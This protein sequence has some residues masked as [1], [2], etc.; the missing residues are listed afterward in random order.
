MEWSRTLWLAARR[1]GREPSFA[2]GT[3]LLLA[4]G[5]G[6]TTAAFGVLDHLLWRPLPGVP[7]SDRLVSLYTSEGRERQG[8]SSY[9]D[10]RDLA[11]RTRAF[12]AVAAFK[13]LQLELN[14]D[15]D[16]GEPIR[17]LMVTGGYFRALGLKPAHGRFFLGEETEPPGAPAVVLGHDLWQ[18][19]FAGR[20]DALGEP[21]SIDGLRCTIVG[22]APPGFA[23]TSEDL[24]AG[25]FV[26]MSLQPHLMGED[27]LG[28]R[29][30]GGVLGIGRLAPRASL[31]EGAADL[32]RVAAELAREF[33]RTNRDRTMSLEPLLD[34]RIS[35]FARSLWHGAG[36]LLAV[37]V[38]LVLMV[39]C[40]NVATLLSTR[41][42]SRLEELGIRR[43]LGA[44]PGRLA[45]ELA[46]ETLLIA[47]SGGACG[48]LA[49]TGVLALAR[50]APL[51]ALHDVV[52]DGRALGVALAATL[53][54]ALLA[55][56][57]PLVAARRQLAAPL[58]A[59]ATSLSRA[60]TVGV[61]LQ[62]MV[63]LVLLVGASLFARTL[64]NLRSVPLGFD[65]RGL[66]VGVLG[67]QPGLPAGE[68]AARW[69]A[70]GDA[71][72]AV[73]GVRAASLT[74]RLPGGSDH[75]SMGV[76][77]IN[78]EGEI[79]Q[80]VSVQAV[81]GDYFRALG[82]RPVAGRGLEAADERAAAAVTVVN[83]RMARRFWPGESVLGRT[84]ELLDV[85]MLTIVG[86]VPDSKDG[87]LRQEV[88]PLFY[89]PWSLNPNPPRELYL[90]ARAP[91]DPRSLREAV[92]RAT[93]AAG[94]GRVR[95]IGSF[96]ELLAVVTAPERTAVTLLAGLS[97]LALLLTAVG[98]YS[99]LAWSV[100]QRTRELGVRAALG[101]D[102]RRL[103]RLVL[104]QALRIAA[105]GIVLGTAGG[106]AAARASRAVL[107]GVAPYDP[108]S[109]LA[110]GALL[111]L[112]AAVAAWW[113]ARRATR[114]DPMTALRG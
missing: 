21:V 28:E 45:G 100:A 16:E 111:L 96:S 17:G 97:G 88:E 13:P 83:E 105:I 64:V 27:L 79:R 110:P 51:A 11:E 32:R 62:V 52:L 38:A 109:L 29:G 22:V 65:P 87:E 114:I 12:S 95:K 104:G 54:S 47:G 72:R 31:A 74:S 94:A 37:T 98:L 71:V 69:Q 76:R 77:L 70:V 102:R 19:R 14:G 18:G 60:R 25:F 93:L 90:V 81:G 57:S 43:T 106:L 91:G 48:V 44:T 108:L 66:L 103:R 89:V 5:I 61:A 78:R 24:H 30:W 80:S 86:V 36:L 75:D 85:G 33:P 40:A 42:G 112:I 23:G 49:A 35:I 6:L 63:S 55:G 113:P 50:R 20:P 10:L 84:F 68:R 99:L 67:A 58:R 41:A 39:A 59:K 7:V 92:R 46:T 53:A 9:L 3:C 1:L 107:F 4:L 101:A 15:G 73:P 26:P 2:I 56:L 82:I 8:V 34:S